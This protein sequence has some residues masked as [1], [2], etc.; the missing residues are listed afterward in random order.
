MSFFRPEAVAVLRTWGVPLLFTVLGGVLIYRGIELSGRGAWFGPLMIALGAFC[1]LVLIGAL[2]RA[3]AAWRG[4]RD[5]PGI[6]TVQEGRI[7][8]FG[9]WGGG[10]LALDA[11]TAVEIRTTDQGP[12]ADD[13]FWQLSDSIG[14]KIEIPGSAKGA[15]ALLDILGTL[16]GFDH[17]AVIRAM[18]ST[19]NAHFVLWHRGTSPGL[20]H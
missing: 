13:L 19:D 20:E 5:G 7:S 1:C 18:G 12:A 11:L 17:I 16:N 15:E 3:V 10:I 8:Y 6:V 2:E 9:P 4:R 14:Q